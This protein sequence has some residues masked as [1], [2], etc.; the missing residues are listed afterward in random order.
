MVW[1]VVMTVCTT[2]ECEGTVVCMV[3][4]VVMTVC[5]TREC[6]GTV[7]CN[8]PACSDDCVYNKGV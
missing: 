1:H 4:H 7:V 6:E 5:T 8:G 2:R 3:W